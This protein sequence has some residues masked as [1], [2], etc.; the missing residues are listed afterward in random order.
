MSEEQPLVSQEETAK[1]TVPKESDSP[2]W[3]LKTSDRKPIALDSEGL[4]FLF[5]GKMLCIYR[6]EL[7][8]LLRERLP[9]DD[10]KVWPYRI[11][12]EPFFK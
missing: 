10:G 12:G 9:K 6:D 7:I 4:I 1:V 3:V 11:R 2:L 8:A 5:E